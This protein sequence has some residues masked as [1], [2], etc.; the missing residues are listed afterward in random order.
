[1][2][3]FLEKLDDLP[4]TI[5]KHFERQNHDVAEVFSIVFGFFHYVA[6]LGLILSVLFGVAAKLGGFIDDIWSKALVVVACSLAY[7]VI[8]GTLSTLIS[9]RLNL[10]AIK[11][12]LNEK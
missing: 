9:I 8:A 1:M 7:L 4:T 10:E 2:Q 3:K 11:N 12:C 6:L 5:G